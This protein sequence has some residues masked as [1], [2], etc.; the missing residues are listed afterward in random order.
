LSAGE[1]AILEMIALGAPLSDV[2]DRLMRLNEARFEGLLASILLLNPDGKRLRHAAA[3]SL[4][5]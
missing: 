4:V 2:L 5:A 3:P 1:D